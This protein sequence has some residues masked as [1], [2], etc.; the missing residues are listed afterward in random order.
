MES[1]GLVLMGIAV[2][3]VGLWLQRVIF[4]KRFKKK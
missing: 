2:W 1:I 4:D 3:V